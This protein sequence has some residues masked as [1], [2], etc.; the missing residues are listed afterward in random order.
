MPPIQIHL[1]KEIEEQFD[2]V[3]ARLQ[4]YT[5]KYK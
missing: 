2:G 5:V 3:W 4:E 1:L